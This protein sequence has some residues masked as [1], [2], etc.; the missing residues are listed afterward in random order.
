MTS[1]SPTTVG[2]RIAQCLA[3][4]AVVAGV[5]IGTA[6]M[7]GAEPTNPRPNPGNEWDIGAYD[8]C[9]KRGSG[10]DSPS[11]QR[12]CCEESGGVWQG[13]TPGGPAGKC[14]APAPLETPPQPQGPSLPPRTAGS[15]PTENAPS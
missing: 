6:A 1:I 9:L 5:A 4:T 15:P 7:A 3:A 14:T 11:S 12:Y 8:D 10:D 13:R 2:I